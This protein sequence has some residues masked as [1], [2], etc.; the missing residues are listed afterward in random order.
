MPERSAMQVNP[1][2]VSC[3]LAGIT[4]LFSLPL[5]LVIWHR[6]TG[7]RI[8]PA[9]VAFAVCFPVFFTGAAIRAGFSTDDFLGFYIRQGFLYG[10]LEEGAKYLALRFLIPTCDSR[11]DAVSYGIGHGMIE[12]YSAGISCIGLI[13]A[14][15]ADPD[16]FFFALFAVIEGAAST[17]A[18]TVLIAYGI[19]TEKTKI[20]LP[21]AIL[22]HAAGNMAVGILIEPAAVAVRAVLTAGACFAAYRCWQAMQ[23]PYGNDW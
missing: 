17:I 12:E 16:I 8:R 20:M 1:V 5:M 4:R 3:F 9:L 18:L 14:G 2:D 6:K 13:G 23:E 19:R 7:A 21:A 10:I 11:E 15:T 22:L